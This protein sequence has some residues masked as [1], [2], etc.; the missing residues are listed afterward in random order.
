MPSWIA[1][2]IVQFV[3][4]V[5]GH[6]GRFLATL[7]ASGLP[8]CIAVSP[9]DAASGQGW[10]H[11]PGGNARMLFFN[12]WQFF[13]SQLLASLVVALAFGAGIDLF[14]HYFA[15]K[16]YL[17][18]SLSTV[19][20][21]SQTVLFGFILVVAI[22]YLVCFF[23]NPQLFDN[24]FSATALSEAERIWAMEALAAALLVCVALGWVV[25]G[26]MV[27]ALAPNGP[28]IAAAPL[29][30]QWAFRLMTQIR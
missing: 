27:F 16:G 9:P 8:A 28:R 29:G 26:A 10:A 24:F 14:L 15:R 1:K 25:F 3:D 21:T 5:M 7:V 20:A 2:L 17:V 4:S 19:R 12:F 13:T 30:M 18:S 11:P 22:Y 6:L 23:H